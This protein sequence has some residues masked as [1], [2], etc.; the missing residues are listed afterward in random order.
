[1]SFEKGGRVQSKSNL[2]DKGTEDEN[3]LTFSQRQLSLGNGE[4]C[5]GNITWKFARRGRNVQRY[6]VKW[7]DG[8]IT[9]VET[10]HIEPVSV[11]GDADGDGIGDADADEQED[12][13]ISADLEVTDDD[14]DDGYEDGGDAGMFCSHLV[15]VLFVLTLYYIVLAV[16]MGGVVEVNETS[17]K[18][19]A[20]IGQDPREETDRFEFQV[21][22]TYLSHTC[23]Y[24]MS[25]S[26]YHPSC[27]TV[28]SKL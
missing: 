14:E 5:F 6:R 3:G 2:F 28:G 16:P 24:L 1:M 19:V 20:A 4:Y 23:F 9:Q 27:Y 11:S 22:P 26:P 12:L 18:R 10:S 15:L 21:H 13:H 8:S 17:W 7:D 25:S